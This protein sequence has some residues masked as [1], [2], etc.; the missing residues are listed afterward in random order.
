MQFFQ[1]PATGGTTWGFTSRVPVNLNANARPAEAEV[2][3]PPVAGNTPLHD[4]FQKAIDVAQRAFNAQN[5][6]DRKERKGPPPPREAADVTAYADLL[7]GADSTDALLA[8]NCDGDTPLHLA[9]RAMDGAGAEAII[10]RYDALLASS[11]PSSSAAA[12]PAALLFTRQNA[13]GQTPLHVACGAAFTAE[14]VNSLLRIGGIGEEASLVI[15]T[16]DVAVAAAVAVDKDNE[17]PL[18][19]LVRTLATP[20]RPLNWS[21][22]PPM[23]TVC[24]TRVGAIGTDPTPEQTANM[25]ALVEGPFKVLLDA[26]LVRRDVV[27]STAQQQQHPFN[28]S[29]GVSHLPIIAMLAL[30]NALLPLLQLVLARAV[31]PEGAVIDVTARSSGLA[32]L[33]MISIAEGSTA[34]HVAALR[35]Q[36]APFDALLAHMDANGLKLCALCGGPATSE[37]QQTTTQVE[38]TDDNNNIVA[39]HRVVHPL[40]ARDADGNT[41]IHC[42]LGVATDTHGGSPFPSLDVAAKVF[43]RPDADLSVR[44]FKLPRGGAAAA[45]AAAAAADDGYP[46]CGNDAPASTP[47]PP[48]S[49]PP[50]QSTACGRTAAVRPSYAVEAVGEEDGGDDADGKSI[51]YCF[52]KMGDDK[53]AVRV[54]YDLLSHVTIGVGESTSAGEGAQMLKLPPWRDVLRAHEAMTMRGFGGY[55]DERVDRAAQERAFNRKCAMVDAILQ[56]TH[57]AYSDG[58]G[59][60]GGDK[61]KKAAAVDEEEAKEGGNSHQSF[62]LPLRRIGFYQKECSEEAKRGGVGSKRCSSE[63]ADSADPTAHSSASSNEAAFYGPFG[64]P[65]FG[66]ASGSDGAFEL[67]L[68]L[69]IGDV[70]SHRGGDGW[71]LLHDAASNV[72]A[73]RWAMSS[74]FRLGRYG[75]DF[76][77][78]NAEG[79][80]ALDIAEAVDKNR[81]MRRQ[82]RDMDP[83][84]DADANA[85]DLI[86]WLREQMGL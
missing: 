57:E 12:A 76:S 67:L 29:S 83:D 66:A 9:A 28:V 61:K 2:A 30:E 26:L 81:R 78:V 56:G 43:L 8:A 49:L 85:A 16:H 55:S 6:W 11:P 13:K 42:A 70:N 31:A 59:E 74:L 14:L 23:Y 47:P 54:L 24:P 71:T 21:Y 10:R 64:S 69:G 3:S 53:K 44:N 65:L 17:T 52:L 36:R 60:E 41:T 19:V 20:M 25:F 5:A 84:E 68:R 4:Y 33:H 45:A 40:Y 79:R 37:Q 15:I 80:T 38:G 18:H 39:H 63:P 73:G 32:K 50:Y 62:V 77:A 75:C 34:L 51:M 58:E 22:R 46:P 48:P 35:R 27:A 86:G 1:Q 7:N 72:A 82:A